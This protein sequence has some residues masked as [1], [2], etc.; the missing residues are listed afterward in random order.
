MRELDAQDP[1]KHLARRQ[2]APDAAWNDCKVE[3]KTDMN[4]AHC[5]C[6]TGCISCCV[7]QKGLP[8][9]E[10]VWLTGTKVIDVQQ[11]YYMTLVQ[12]QMLPCYLQTAFI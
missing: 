6:K 3:S 2:L 8:P 11:Y 12:Q 4:L 9:E 7:Q 10:D 1:D 5:D